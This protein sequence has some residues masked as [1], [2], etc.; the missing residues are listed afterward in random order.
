MML[1]KARFSSW[2]GECNYVFFMNW[3]EY[4]CTRKVYVYYMIYVYESKI[5]HTA[6]TVVSAT[7]SGSPAQ[8]VW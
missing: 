6:T 1:T 4:V 7:G 8:D 2:L 3:Y 5:A